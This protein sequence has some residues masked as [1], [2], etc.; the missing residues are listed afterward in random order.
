MLAF[1]AVAVDVG[2]VFP[3][4]DCRVG[5]LIEYRGRQNGFGECRITQIRRWGTGVTTP[6]RCQKIF[7]LFEA[8]AEQPGQ[9]DTGTQVVDQLAV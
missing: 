5:H 6:P 7:S 8:S 1:V 9:S 4:S 3:E 2:V